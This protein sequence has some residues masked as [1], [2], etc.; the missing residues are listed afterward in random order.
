MENGVN[1]S[2]GISDANYRLGRHISALRDVLRS[3]L[4]GDA[5]P[6]LGSGHF[7]SLELYDG[8]AMPVEFGTTA[9]TPVSEESKRTNDKPSS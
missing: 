1:G 7:E 6:L 9:A 2:R 5:H 3:L 4:V 8:N